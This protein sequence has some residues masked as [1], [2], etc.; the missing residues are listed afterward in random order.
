MPNMI[1]GFIMV[2]AIAIGA[3]FLVLNLG[4][5]VIDTAKGSSEIK[6]AEI[7]MR[8]VDN[9]MREVAREGNG[10]VRKY[11]FAAPKRFEILKGEDAVVFEGETP[12]ALFDFNTRTKKE[13]L[14]YITGND[15]GCSEAD[16]NS[17]S[18][19]DLI[20]ENGYVR[21]VLN[22][23]ARASPFSNIDTNYAMLNITMKTTGVS[24]QPVNSSIYIDDNSSSSYGNGYSELLRTGTNLPFCTA[25]FFV[26]AS[27]VDY[28]VY[29]RLYA[30]ADFLTVYVRN[31]V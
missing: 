2:F 11:A 21:F 19:T 27:A 16:G 17:D 8:L 15:V 7:I 18:A 30:G 28:D 12:S 23:T 22:R 24:I 13:N 14:L 10:S 31:I 20:L 26:N 4:K 29:Y 3:M 1:V 25:H 6:N 5:P 9:Y